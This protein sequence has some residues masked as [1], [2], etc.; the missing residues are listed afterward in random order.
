MQRESPEPAPSFTIQISCCSLERNPDLQKLEVAGQR[1][2]DWP[3][4]I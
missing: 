3:F 1:L 4:E 2:L